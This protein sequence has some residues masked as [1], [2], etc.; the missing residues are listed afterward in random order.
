MLI[1]WRLLSREQ[2]NFHFQFNLPSQC[3]VQ[4][5]LD[6]YSN[7]DLLLTCV[8]Q[9]RHILQC[10]QQLTVNVLPWQRAGTRKKNDSKGEVVSFS[11]AYEMAAAIN[12]PLSFCKNKCLLLRCRL[13]LI[14][15][16]WVLLELSAYL[17]HHNFLFQF[18]CVGPISAAANTPKAFSYNY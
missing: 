11:I 4:Y 2:I 6:Q 1:T 17:R 7:I 5:Q 8:P 12:V 16:S 14:K 15:W 9:S 3:I 18:P 13:D 10:K